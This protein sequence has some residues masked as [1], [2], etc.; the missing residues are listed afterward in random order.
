M[1]QSRRLIDLF[2]SFSF[3]SGLPQHQNGMYGLQHT[4]HHFTSFDNVRS[5]PILLQK[6]NVRTGII[7]K[8][9]V[10]PSTV[11]TTLSKCS[12]TQCPHVIIASL[13]NEL[14]RARNI[15]LCLWP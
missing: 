8:K 4:F 9:H 6:A 12:F 11:S 3:S 10:G 7:G 14:I 15:L 2:D 5:L 1:T 13:Q